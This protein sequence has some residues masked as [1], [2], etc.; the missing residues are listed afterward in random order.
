VV[1]TLPQPEE[2]RAFVSRMFDT[3]A[4]RYDAMNR[5][6]TFG[7]DRGWR[8]ATLA[9]LA[10]RPGHVIIDLGC[11]TG[12]LS[13]GARAAGARPVGVDLSAGML[14]QAARRGSAGTLVRADAG[15]LPLADG[16]CDGAVS[17][18]ALRNF[19]SIETVLRECA[20]VVR[21][22]G[23]VSLLEIDRPDSGPFATLFTFYFQRVVPLLGSLVSRG[24]AYRYLAGSTVY[25]PPW[26]ELRTMLERAGFSR[27]HK[28]SMGGGSVQLVTAVRSRS[29]SRRIGEAG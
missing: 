22:G 4:P 8:R 20:R 10:I 23:R 27:V 26:P 11:G 9:S 21:D 7:M 14:A 16:S 28:R 5:L 1:V 2:K 17:G 24:Y 29:P 6:M 12:D 19:E 25:L 18:F 13:D 3:I 15:R